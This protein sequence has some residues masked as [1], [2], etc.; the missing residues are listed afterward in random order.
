MWIKSALFVYFAALLVAGNDALPNRRGKNLYISLYSFVL[1]AN[2]QMAPPQRDHASALESDHSCD[3][4]AQS[5]N[6][7]EQNH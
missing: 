5:L 1:I 7:M 3:G 4:L 2:S 6:E